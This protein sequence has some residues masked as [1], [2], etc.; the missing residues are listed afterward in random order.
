[1]DDAYGPPFTVTD[2]TELV[3]AVLERPLHIIKYLDVPEGQAPT[4]MQVLDAAL[5]VRSFDAATKARL[6][7]ARASYLLFEEHAKEA[8]FTERGKRVHDALEGKSVPEMIATLDDLL[9]REDSHHTSAGIRLARDI[10]VDGADSI[11]S[12]DSPEA[13][14]LEGSHTHA[15][16]GLQQVAQQD[17]AAA[18]VTQM[19]GDFPGVAAAPGAISAGTAFVVIYE[20]FFG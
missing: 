7:A 19:I 13:E 17:A 1:V 16:S 5:Q 9:A 6:E 4:T 20:A 3:K 15:L 8:A 14:L 2:H 11:Y 12:P 10:L 18:Y